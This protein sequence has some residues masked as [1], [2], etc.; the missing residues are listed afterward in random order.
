MSLE[1]IKQNQDKCKPSMAA[2]QRDIR[3]PIH[4]C[5]IGKYDIRVGC[6]NTTFY[7][8]KCGIEYTFTIKSQKK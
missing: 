1:E 7:C 2:Y 5:L 4:N 3:C 8:Q 6:I